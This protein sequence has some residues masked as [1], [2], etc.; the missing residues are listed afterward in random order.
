MQ[1]AQLLGVSLAALST[2]QF[3]AAQ[4]TCSIGQAAPAVDRPTV[5]NVSY[6]QSDKTIAETAVASGQFKTLTAAL[7]AAELVEALNGETE[8]TVFAPTDAAFEALEREKP[9]TIATLLRPEN[10]K[11]LQAI[12]KYHVVKGK[13]PASKVTTMS[14]ATTLQGQ[15]LDI[16]ASSMG[17]KIDEA[18]VTKT[19][20]QCSNGIIHVIDKVMLPVTDTVV[21]IA[22]DAGSFNTLLAAV[23]A[24]GLT[25]TL[26]G[27]GPFT[28]FAPTDE[29]FAA[30]ERAKPGTIEKLLRPDNRDQLVSILTYHVVSG[31]VYADKVVTMRSAETLQ[32]SDVRIAVRNDTVRIDDA[33]VVKT[34]IEAAN[35]V[36]HVIDAVILPE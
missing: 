4:S 29:A 33:T 25:S 16:K 2:A 21:D 8:Y 3:A 5:E 13:V 28:I 12:L 32:G 17:V 30:L 34:D 24:A 14:T 15:R 31:R 35:G 23:D 9:G 6:Q 22:K 10:K 36:I 18:K 19:D 20:I 7:G 11:M 27:D 26:E 1:I